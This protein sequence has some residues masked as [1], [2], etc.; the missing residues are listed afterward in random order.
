M[1]I[2]TPVGLLFREGKNPD[3]AV[4]YN[5]LFGFTLA[6]QVAQTGADAGSQRAF[7]IPGTSY[8]G[9]WANVELTRTTLF[10]SNPGVAYFQEQV[11]KPELK[12]LIS[13][14][15]HQMLDLHPDINWKEL[16]QGEWTETITT[17]QE[18][19]LELANLF[20]QTWLNLSRRASRVNRPV[21]TKVILA[22]MDSLATG[23][24]N[25]LFD[26][27][28]TR[29]RV[30]SNIEAVTLILRCVFQ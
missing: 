4:G 19:D 12:A 8:A 16:P 15:Q 1:I 24:S 29:A 5:K 20:V 6:A 11:T 25:A 22:D 2:T 7:S 28:K 3:F 30:R 9:F 18:E 10:L 21:Q 17:W 27:T 13:T 14:I 23:L 26:V